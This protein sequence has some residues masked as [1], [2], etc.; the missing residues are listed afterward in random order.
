MSPLAQMQRQF[1][2]SL[3][4]GDDALLP[5]LAANGPV[6]PALGWAI[7]VNAYGARLREVLEND[8]PVLSQYLGDEL[9]DALCEGFIAARPSRLR[10]L[11]DFGGP[12]PAW[13][14]QA[15]P[16][17]AQPQIAELAAWERRLMDS[18]DAA[19][20]PVASWSE[21]LALAPERWPT[22]TLQLH[23]SLQ[24][25]N[26]Q[27]NSVAIWKAMKAGQAPPRAEPTQEEHWLLWRDTAL[28]TRYRPMS[29]QEAAMLG[30]FARGGH[31]AD[32]CE[33]LLQWHAAE[34]VPALAVQWLK[35]WTDEGWI[36]RWRDAPRREA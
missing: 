26:P 27:W 11:R 29:P 3:R 24:L 17:A 25:L 7:Y 9:W 28:L 19:D 13:L 36:S 20:A 35:D 2:A 14:R 18:F 21:L 16:F 15:A 6:S 8:H 23:P 10:S 22:L 34:S 1:M 32:A 12:L 31:F 5:Q 33:C 30:H 4:R